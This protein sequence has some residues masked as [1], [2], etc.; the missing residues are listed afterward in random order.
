MKKKGARSATRADDKGRLAAKALYE[1]LGDEI[2]LMHRAT[3]G[4][5]NMC[6]DLARTSPKGVKRIGKLVSRVTNS[7]LKLDEIYAKNKP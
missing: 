6:I 4:F 7:M 2:N 1:N 3:A 5:V